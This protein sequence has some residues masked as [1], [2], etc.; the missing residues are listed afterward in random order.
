MAPFFQRPSAHP[1]SISECWPLRAAHDPM[2]HAPGRMR[3]RQIV[4]DCITPCSFFRA[5]SNE[6][7]EPSGPRSASNI[8]SISIPSTGLSSTLRSN[9]HFSHLASSTRT[10]N[11]RDF[12]GR[13]G[14]GPHMATYLTR[15]S[16]SAISGT[17]LDA[18]DFLWSSAAALPGAR[19]SIYTFPA[20]PEC[21][22]N[23]PTRMPTPA[24]G[25]WSSLRM[26]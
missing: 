2:P 19:D 3:C 7:C 18:R 14:C 9:T 13:V 4:R 5:N 26:S 25:A 10:C 12:C 6:T 15:R 8:R 23:F 11:S 1:C 17:P 21:S 16:F 20:F 24:M 22:E